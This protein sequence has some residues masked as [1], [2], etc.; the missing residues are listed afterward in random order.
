M[1]EK[2]Q[3][4][5]RMNAMPPRGTLLE[6]LDTELHKIIDRV[7]EIHGIRVAAPSPAPVAAP[8]RAPVAAPVP[9]PAGAV[10]TGTAAVAPVHV[11]HQSELDIE[12]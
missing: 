8:K 6:Q 2:A 7:R 4:V 3:K 10:A 11:E 1:R 5:N 12:P 9:A